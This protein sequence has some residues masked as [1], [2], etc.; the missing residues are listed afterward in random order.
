[1]ALIKFGGG[2]VDARGSIAGNVFSRNRYGNYMRAR[3]K[4]VN[5]QSV[6]QSAIRALMALISQA[7]FAVVSIAQRA[8]WAVYASNVPETNKLGE[9]IRLSGFNQYVKSNLAAQNAGLPAIADGPSVF[10]KPGED[11]TYAAVI[12]EATQTIA[13]TFD[14]TADWANEDD[15]GLI[16]QMGIP[17]ND[18]IEFFD[19]PWRHAGTIL[20]D[21]VTPPVTGDPVTAPFPVVANQKIFTRARIIRADGRLGDWFRSIALAGA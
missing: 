11:P 1:M 16:V 19:G 8:D 18:S 14:A 2:V 9:V 13:N 7:W 12:S 21:S 17:Q 5:P 20:G 6:R 15:A 10:T 4:P 3:T